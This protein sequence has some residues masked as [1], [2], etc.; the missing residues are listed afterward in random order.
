M[1]N[2]EDYTDNYMKIPFESY[3]V[4]YRR[5][6]VL[7]SVKKYP[8]DRILE[9]GCGMRPLF[10]DLDDY[11]IMTIVEPSAVFV[12]NVMKSKKLTAKIKIKNG[13]L[14]SMLQELEADDYDF[15]VV[16]SLL[17]EVD[18]PELLLHTLVQLCSSNTIVHINV[19]NAFS[20]H[21][22]LAHKMGMIRD[23]F[24]QS[25][26]QKKMQQKNTYDL[27][28]LSSAVNSVGFDVVEKGSFFPKYFTHKQMQEMLDKG[29]INEDILEGMYAMS[30][31]LPEYGSEIYVNV[32]RNV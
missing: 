25:M 1:R 28:S 6:K 11:E 31:L 23:V 18:D 14:E 9:V 17:H 15:I 16:T 13:F 22:L 29:I 4:K 20:L 32:K 21:R 2:I 7:E 27:L 26:M 3:Q 10:F 19:P 24:E 8:H 5:K 12:D 30:D